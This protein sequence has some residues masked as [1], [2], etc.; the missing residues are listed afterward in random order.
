M[1]VQQHGPNKCID[2]ENN[3]FDTGLTLV[4]TLNPRPWENPSYPLN[5]SLHG[6]QVP[7]GR[8]PVLG[9]RPTH[10]LLPSV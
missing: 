2:K 5:S 3:Y 6:L 10:S 9:V 1:L 4:V 8:A 7:S